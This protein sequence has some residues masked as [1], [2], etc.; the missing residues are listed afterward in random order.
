MSIAALLLASQ[1]RQIAGV[2]DQQDGCMLQ[3][4]LLSCRSWCQFSPSDT[5][6]P[7]AHAQQPCTSRPQRSLEQMQRAAD[8]LKMVKSANCFMINAC[9]KQVIHKTLKLQLLHPLP[10]LA[11]LTAR[12]LL[13]RLLLLHAAATAA[14]LSC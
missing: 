1:Q 2:A 4:P 7:Y 10:R 9:P 8:F 14:L 13:L 3:S 6:Q 12:L 5:S 11:Q